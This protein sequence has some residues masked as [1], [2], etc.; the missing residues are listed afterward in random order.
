MEGWC[1]MNSTM[2]L[3]VRASRG[4]LGSKLMEPM[5]ISMMGKLKE[6]KIEVNHMQT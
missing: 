4:K 5:D 2:Q 3:R 6:V 1:D